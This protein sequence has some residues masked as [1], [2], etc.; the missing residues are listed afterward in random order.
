M[1]SAETLRVV[2]WNIQWL[3]G[4]VPDAPEQV[5]KEHMKNAQEVLRKLNP[6]VLLLQEI[7]DWATAEELV[8][9][10]PGFQV[11]VTSAF[12]ERPQNQVV[13]SR[14]PADS[15]WYAEWKRVP[16][17][18]P[19]GYAFAAL[20]LPDE[21][22][23]L[24][25][26]VHFKSNRGDF[27]DNLR[28]RA[29]AALQLLRHTS[30]MLEIYGKRG[31]SAVVIGGDFNTSLDDE[32]FKKEATLQAL[33]R[34]GLRWV[35][36]GVPF[37]KRVTIPGGNGPFPDGCFD[38]LFV[39]GA[40]ASSSQVLVDDSSSDHRPVLVEIDL[41][42]PFEPET[43]DLSVIQ[44]LEAASALP[45]LPVQPKSPDAVDVRNAPAIA[46]AKDKPI[47]LRGVVSRI[48]STRSGE[49]SFID[50]EGVEPR[51][52]LV[53]IVRKEN[54]AKV[55]EPLGGTLSSLFGR[56]I[57]LQGV[58]TYYGETPQIEVFKPE[59]IRVVSGFLGGTGDE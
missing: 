59:Q 54:L 38:H 50:F 22:F 46:A 35:H 14:L 28:K 20:K 29:A 30:Q 11:H 39:L 48:G 16:A 32:R 13:A 58:V 5:Q 10:L 23:L 21:R 18:P 44:E 6:D 40:A 9:V 41:D 45:V 24:C 33:I 7:R 27:D 4:R 55:V 42:K 57:E 19:R 25:Y 31:Q 56:E 47:L 17:D 34:A 2:T 8:S 49:I 15:A 43:L 3:P 51:V 53:G 12:D 37:E 52:G 1:A 36:E 26:S